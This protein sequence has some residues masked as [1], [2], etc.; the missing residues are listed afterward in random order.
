MRCVLAGSEGGNTTIGERRGT[1]WVWDR[2]WGRIRP[3]ALC[4]GAE[5]LLMGG[6]CRIQPLALTSWRAEGSGWGMMGLDGARMCLDGHW[7]VQSC[8]RTL[9]RSAGV[10]VE[11]QGGRIRP[12]RSIGE[13]RVLV[14][15]LAG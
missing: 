6:G 5:G 15:G 13:Q 8:P 1:G 12:S 2:C 10:V 9:V 3:L 7:G 11:G 4:W 14:M